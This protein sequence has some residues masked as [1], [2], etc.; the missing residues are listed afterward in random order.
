MKYLGYRQVL[1]IYRRVIE[2]TGGSAGIRDEGLLRSALARP[3]ATFGGEDL[4]PTLF[5]KA[6]ALAESLVLNHPFVDGNKRMAFE[7][8]DVFLAMNGYSLT[9]SHD[10]SFRFVMQIIQ[11]RITIQDAAG[12][13]AKHARRLKSS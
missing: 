10:Q 9:A 8:L 3:Q 6:A 4:Y 12:W 13:L 5:E 11:R 2:E 1:W 7:C